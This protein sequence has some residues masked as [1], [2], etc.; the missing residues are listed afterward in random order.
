MEQ[1]IKDKIVQI[2][3]QLKK[4]TGSFWKDPYRIR[5]DIKCKIKKVDDLFNINN[6]T[7]TFEVV[8]YFENRFIKIY[9]NYGDESDK[10]QTLR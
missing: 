6:F 9:R 8:L 7:S 2:I 3:Q 10:I 1:A 5:V 4:A